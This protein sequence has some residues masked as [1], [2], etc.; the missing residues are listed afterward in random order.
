MTATLCSEQMDGWIDWSVTKK[1][2]ISPRWGDIIQ[3]HVLML[4]FFYIS[5]FVSIR[6]YHAKYRENIKISTFC[7]EANT[8]CRNFL[9]FAL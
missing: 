8:K 7:I 6:T 2:Y 4:K 9:H 5:V 1:K 3:P